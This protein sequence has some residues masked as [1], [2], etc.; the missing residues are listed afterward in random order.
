MNEFNNFISQY[1]IELE[2]YLKQTETLAIVEIDNELRISNYNS[3]FAKMISAKK[4]MRGIEIYSCLLPESHDILPLSGSV[5]KLAVWLNFTSESSSAVPLH[6]KIFK[7]DSGKHIIFAGHLSLTSELMIQEMTIM[8]NEMANMTR[9]LH[10]KNKELQEANSK[11]KV[12]GGIIPIC[13]H[14]KKIRDDKGY[15]N[16]LEKFIAENSEAQ[17]SH[18]ICDPCLEKYYPDKDD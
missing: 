6:C 14:C 13:M 12:L 8:S 5:T 3:C 17:F 7:A 16:Q 11:I 18:G 1:S 10:Q 9:S 2:D 4:N 15:W